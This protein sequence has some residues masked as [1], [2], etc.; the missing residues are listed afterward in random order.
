MIN[1]KKKKLYQGLHVIIF[2]SIFCV[3]IAKSAHQNHRHQ[4]SEENNH[5]DGIEN[6]EPMNLQ[7]KQDVLGAENTKS[8]KELMGTN[9][10]SFLSAFSLEFCFNENPKYY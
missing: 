10:L 6:R 7:K 9:C 2:T 5:H 8:Y 3:I 4:P 1:E